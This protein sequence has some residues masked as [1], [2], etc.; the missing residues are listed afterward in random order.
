MKEV[1]IYKTSLCPYC[2]SAVKFLQ[3]KGIPYQ[4]QSLDGDH[5]LRMKLSAENGG[6]RTVPMIFIGERFVGGYTELVAAH[7]D[8]RLDAWMA[9]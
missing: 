1:M 7:K 8:G 6:W 4:E 9:E 2:V 5:E 3:S